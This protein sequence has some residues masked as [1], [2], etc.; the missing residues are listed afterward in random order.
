MKIT[1]RRYPILGMANELKEIRR[2]L[3]GKSQAVIGH[4]V[5]LCLYPNN[6]LKNHW[7][8]EVWAILHR[9]PKYTKTNKPPKAQFIFN[10]TWGINHDTIDGD[11]E[12]TIDEYGEPEISVEFDA[13][14]SRLSDYFSWIANELSDRM[15][16]LKKDVYAK[17][18]ELGM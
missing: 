8:T 10:S 4:L 12:L 18:D 1:K 3:D 14:Y 17:L 11:I 6:G 16:I 5:K 2:Q 15:I 9:V 7:R 13:I